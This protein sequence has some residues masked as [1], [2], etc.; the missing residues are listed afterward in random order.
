MSQNSLIYNYNTTYTNTMLVP[1]I[2]GVRKW[3]LRG[4]F[5]CRPSG[6]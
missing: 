6:G 1:L 2:F 4:R 5:G 3:F